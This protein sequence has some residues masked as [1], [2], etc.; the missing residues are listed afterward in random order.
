MY[1]VYTS[2]NKRDL[3]GSVL[4]AFALSLCLAVIGML[5]GTMV[6]PALFMPLMVVEFIMILSAFLLRKKKSVG[7]GFLFAFAFISGITTY[8]IVAHYLATSGAKVVLSAFTATLVIFAVM[9]FVGTKTKKDLSFLSG[10]L[11]TALLA[12]VVIGLINI[13]SPFSSTALFVASIIGT[14][15]FSL[16]IMFDFNR[17][18]RMEFTEEAVPLLALNLFLDFI[19]LFLELLR[20]IGFISRD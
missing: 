8:P 12:L 10:I 11:F 9:S 14:V 17:M 3:M 2:V 16:Y 18:K 5:I 4:K 15:V 19:N 20:L 13:F 7:Y 1:D 6:P